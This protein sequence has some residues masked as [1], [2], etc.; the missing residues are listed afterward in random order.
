M[1]KISS[2]L[3]LIF[4]CFLIFTLSSCGK[5]NRVLTITY[6]NHTFDDFHMYTSVEKCEKDNNIR[7]HSTLT[8]KFTVEEDASCL[9]FVVGKDNQTVFQDKLCFGDN[10]YFKV[11]YDGEKMWIE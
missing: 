5:E 6:V 7:G 2:L 1:K 10:D 11:H 9:D 4:A 8:D 3:M